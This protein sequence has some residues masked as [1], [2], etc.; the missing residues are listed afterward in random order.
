M[1]H[2]SGLVA[3]TYMTNPAYTAAQQGK[4][5]ATGAGTGLASSGLSS[6]LGPAL[7]GAGTNLANAAGKGAAL[8]L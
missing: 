4:Q 5:G 2:A 3:P 7:G 1:E 6:L 8:A